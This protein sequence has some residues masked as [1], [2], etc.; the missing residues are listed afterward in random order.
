MSQPGQCVEEELLDFEVQSPLK[1]KDFEVQ[2][3]LKLKDFEVQSPLKLK[4]ESLENVNCDE[5]A[6]TKV[7]GGGQYHAGGFKKELDADH[8][9]DGEVKVEDLDNLEDGE[10][11]E[12]EVSDGQQA[13]QAEFDEKRVCR[14]FASGR[15]CMW[16]Q[17]CI[18]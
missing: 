11:S 17:V 14:H 1:L 18:T 9:E 16:G 8:L 7:M 6:A 10:I 3:P 15:I 13:G 2:S 12:E 5:V 4:E